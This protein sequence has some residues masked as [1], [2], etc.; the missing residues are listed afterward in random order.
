MNDSKRSS[1]STTHHKSNV[2]LK[3]YK[4]FFL[5][6]IIV[7]QILKPMEFKDKKKRLKYEHS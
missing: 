5:F 1:P 6:L 3:I 4:S 7:S 2:D